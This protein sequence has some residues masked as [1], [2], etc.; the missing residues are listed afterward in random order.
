M[1]QNR[2]PRPQK[3]NLS[4]Y[5]F[6]CKTGSNTNHQR[7]KKLFNKGVKTIKYLRGKQ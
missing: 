5:N 1:E 3:H 2:E 4:T 7:K 6:A